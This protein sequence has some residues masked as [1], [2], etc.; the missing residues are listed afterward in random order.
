VWIERW[1]ARIGKLL[2][3]TL[4]SGMLMAFL[5]LEE[6]VITV[7]MGENGHRTRMI[8]GKDRGRPTLSCTRSLTDREDEAEALSG[9]LRS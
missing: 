5:R 4:T 3:R 9:V 8:K 1:R 2:S 7:L 6:V